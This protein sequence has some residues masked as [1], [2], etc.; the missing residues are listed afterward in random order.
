MYKDKK[1]LIV[2]PARGGSKGI[3][4][5]NIKVLCDKPLIAHVIDTI[6]Q[7][8]YVDKFIVTTDDYEISTISN[9]YGANVV[10][11]PEDLSGDDV[12]L[13]PVINHVVVNLEE[14]NEI[15]DIIV[16]IQPTSP[17]LKSITIDSAIKKMVDA[18]ID[19][20]IT[21]IDD[22]HLNWE[23]DEIS[24]KYKP[25]YKDRLNRQYL[26]KAY[27]ETGAIL[28]TKRQYVT[29]GSRIG[30][31]I[32]LIEIDYNES[33]DIDSYSDWW[34]A[35]ILLNK[36][37]ILIKVDADETIGAGHI[38]R[39]L[40]IAS[41]ICKH[42][43]MFLVHEKMELGLKIIK[44]KNYKYETHDEN[45]LLQK[46]EDYNP[47]III[48]DILDTKENYISFLKSK[49]IFVINFEDLGD[50]AKKADLV[51]N[52][53]YEHKIPLKNA[54]IGYKYYLLRDEFYYYKNMN[55]VI[56]EEVRNILITFG[57]VDINNFTLKIIN[58]LK[59]IDYRHKITVILGIGY[60]NKE[61]IKEKY[62]R[63]LNVKILENVSNISEHM[64]INDLIFTSAGRTIYEVA[65]T[66]TPCICMCQNERELSHLFA[67]SSNGFIN[68]GLGSHVHDSIIKSTVTSVLADF[69]I[70]KTLRQRMENIDLYNGFNNLSKEISKTY[71]KINNK[72]LEL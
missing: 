34:L 20:I 62:S 40:I 43:V 5:K 67:N 8:N 1:I 10:S 29:K 69:D 36:K 22:R 61:E 4:S 11:R 49:N 13:D 15:Y 52:A 41:K 55:K 26:P 31:N 50:G 25:I 56:N 6:K 17:L 70:R 64:F 44:E 39:C 28:A 33:I 42:D 38:Y 19:T 57:G 7:S 9:R 48:N 68:L 46:I 12:P 21:V 3:P 51:V 66:K 23:Y 18:N 16:T 14:K 71:K 58:I 45:N 60:K 27:R 72:P 32:D 2:I 53:L 54:L 63:D 24:K 35:E 59:E 65:S 37:K 47:D 30:N